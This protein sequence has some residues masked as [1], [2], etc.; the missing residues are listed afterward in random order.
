[1]T[2]A[3][4]LAVA[5]VLLS[6]S[7]TVRADDAAASGPILLIGDSIAA[8][9]AEIG[10]SVADVLSAKTGVDVTLAAIPGSRVLGGPD[11]VPQQYVPG[12]WRWVVVQG[13]GNDLVVECGCGACD[14]ALDRL[15]GRDGRTGAIADL[16]RRIRADGASVALWSYYA[17]PGDAPFPFA[18]CNDELVEVHARLARLA[19][20]DDGIVLVDGREAV[21]P[22]RTDLYDRDRV[23]PSPAGSRAIGTRIAEALVEAEAGRP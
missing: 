23:H 8:W 11:P 1:V 10:A 9:N 6:A 17:M 18:R 5:L 15:I 16:V 20:R 12:P 7:V 14:A 21:R 13:G 19:A 2:V 22:D 3:R 4:R